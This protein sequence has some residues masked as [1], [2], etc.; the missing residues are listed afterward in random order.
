[1]GAC[2]KFRED[3]VLLH[4]IMEILV[5]ITCKQPV[6]GI[7]GTER[8]IVGEL[9][10]ETNAYKATLRRVVSIAYIPGINVFTRMLK[11]IGILTLVMRICKC[12]KRGTQKDVQSFRAVIKV[13]PAICFPAA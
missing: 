2:S 13:E 4:I 12:A 7:G 6:E 3:I 1:M 10:V 11:V 9:V 8:L 5:G